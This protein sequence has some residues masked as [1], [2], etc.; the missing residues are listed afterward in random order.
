MKVAGPESR[1]ARARPP[2]QV[3]G[4]LPFPTSR[5]CSVSHRRQRPV[6]LC[7]PHSS[8]FNP[9]NAE[10]QPASFIGVLSMIAQLYQRQESRFER[11]GIT[12]I[13]AK[14]NAGQ[15]EGFDGAPRLDSLEREFCEYFGPSRKPSDIRIN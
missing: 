11:L 14:R 10:I 9:A 5:I 7:T 6:S 15:V 3:S 12:A 1:A 4:E 13:R 8:L 2:L